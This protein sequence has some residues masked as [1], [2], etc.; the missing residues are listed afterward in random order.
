ME[1]ELNFYEVRLANYCLYQSPTKRQVIKYD[2]TDFYNYQHREWYKP[3]QITLEWLKDLGFEKAYY[4]GEVKKGNTLYIS[5]CN[6]FCLVESNGRFYH[7]EQEHEDAMFELLREVK[8][9]HRL[10]F[11]YFEL[12]DSE[13]FKK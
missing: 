4:Q 2:A 7:A 1:K 6:E 5:D 10:Q 9:F 12:T 11:L 3:I 8:Y 13:L